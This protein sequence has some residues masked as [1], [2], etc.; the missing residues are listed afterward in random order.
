[1]V[2]SFLI[3]S[4]YSIGRFYFVVFPILFIYFITKEFVVNFEISKILFFLFFLIF[5]LLFLFLILNSF[6]RISVD[7]K[8]KQ[9]NIQRLPIKIYHKQIPFNK[10]KSIIFT[11][12]KMYAAEVGVN[13]VR[14]IIIIGIGK[15][16]LFRKTISK[17]NNYDLLESLCTE[18]FEVDFIVAEDT[19][20]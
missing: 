6:L 18:Y 10:I 4:S 8:N 3:A 14:E 9:I 19:E 20:P 12:E 13:W 11:E 15:E 1:M 17:I 16:I 7:Y 2:K 5:L